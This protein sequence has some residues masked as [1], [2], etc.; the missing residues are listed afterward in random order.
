M[1]T[2]DGVHWCD[3]ALHHVVQ[4][5]HPVL[6]AGGHD[7]LAVAAEAGLV[8]REVLQVDALDLRVRLPV[9]LR[10]QRPKT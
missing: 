5:E 2:S 7:R 9:H 3:P 6:G 8:D 4:V 10:A 1:L